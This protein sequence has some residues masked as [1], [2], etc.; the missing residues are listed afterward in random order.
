M[1]TTAQGSLA[2]IAIQ[3]TAR[4]RH[5]HIRTHLNTLTRIQMGTA[6]IHTLIR[7]LLGMD[8]RTLTAGIRQTSIQ[9]SSTP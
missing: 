4:Q 6:I 5:I 7:T 8:I 2:T 3:S 9:T 1:T